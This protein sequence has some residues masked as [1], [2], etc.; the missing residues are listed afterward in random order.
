MRISCYPS[1][2]LR[3]QTGDESSPQDLSCFDG[4]IVPTGTVINLYKNLTA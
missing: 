2:T 1:G 3:E 4:K